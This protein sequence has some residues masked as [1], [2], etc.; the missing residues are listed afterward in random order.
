VGT[1]RPG[2]VLAWLVRR[3]RKKTS[4]EFE[5]RYGIVTL[6]A[7]GVS[8]GMVQQLA[9]QIGRRRN[10]ELALALWEPADMKRAC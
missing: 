8:A 10:H 3:G 5:T 2:E 4:D 7:F 9:K 6:K 1:H